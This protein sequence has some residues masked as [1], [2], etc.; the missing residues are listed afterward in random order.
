MSAATKN[1]FQRLLFSLQSRPGYTLMRAFA[2]FSLLRALIPKVCDFA[3]RLRFRGWTGELV[4]ESYFP[5]I[6]VEEFVADLEKDGI[7]LGLKLPPDLV[8]SI[9]AYA[10]NSICYADREPESGFA[11]EK[12]EE[13]EKILDKRVLVAQYFN[14]V[15]DCP[16]IARL[17]RDPV[18]NRIAQEYL[19][20]SPTFVGANLWWT[21]PVVASE[22][23]RNRHAHLFH[24]DV[25]DFKFLKFFF[26]LTDVDADDGAH[27]CVLRSQGLPPT[28]N[29]LD[30][31]NVRRYSDAEISAQYV[32]D[33]VLEI[34]GKA[35]DGFAEDTWCIHKGQTPTRSPRL[36]LQLQ[37]ALFDYGAMH[38]R[39][40]VNQL[41]R[42]A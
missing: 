32:R 18:L 28:R 5:N 3:A 16:E 12:R 15:S 7:A 41:R 42:L 26:Y 8:R 31:W 36:L 4:E 29:F 33:Q 40:D 35:G 9:R 14:T 19:C 34:C 22:E 23:D 1:R 20:A 13:A 24:R 11:L 10:D 27:V 30:R 25:D 39:R 17:A 38:D 6:T 2:R 21:F 37:F